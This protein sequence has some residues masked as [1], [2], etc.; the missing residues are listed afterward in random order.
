MEL[1]FN[2]NLNSKVMKHR[3]YILTIVFLI[4]A[5]IPFVA[6]AY[7]DDL[8]KYN[9]K[10]V[11]K[12]S[13]VYESPSIKPA[14]FPRLKTREGIF[15]YAK[16]L[17]YDL[18]TLFAT[19]DFEDI[20]VSAIELDGDK[21]EIRFHLKSAYFIS[22]VSFEG[23]VHFSNQQLREQASI[24]Y[25]EK[26]DET[27]IE[28]GAKKL[29]AYYNN[30]GYFNTHI[31]WEFKK[32]SESN[33]GELI[34]KISDAKPAY[35]NKIEIEGLYESAEGSNSPT[36]ELPGLKS[37]Q[38][39]RFSM[40]GINS[41]L[42]ES[43]LYLWD[44]NYFTT[45]LYLL[46]NTIDPATGSV[47]LKIK[48][49]TDGIISVVFNEK[50]IDA[51][52]FKG[53]LEGKP[54][55][56]LNSETQLEWSNLVQEYYKR[57]GYPDAKVYTSIFTMEQR[58][59][60]FNINIKKVQ[61]LV[62]KGKVKFIKEIDFTFNNNI[63]KNELRS[64]L[65]N[66]KDLNSGKILYTTDK[67]DQ[68][69]EQ[70]NLFYRSNGYLEAKVLQYDTEEFDQIEG[71]GINIKFQID[72][73]KQSRIKEIQVDGDMQ[74]DKDEIIRRIGID[75]GDVFIPAALEK[76]SATIRD[77]VLKTY[78]IEVEVDAK[79]YKDDENNA[80]IA[81][82]VNESEMEFIEQIIL[83][84]NF[85]TDSDFILRSID[86]KEGDK[87]TRSALLSSQLKL[88][89]LGLFANIEFTPLD[90]DITSQSKRVLLKVQETV[91]IL[92]TYGGGVDTE[93][94]V[95]GTF[96]ISHNNLGGTGKKADFSISLGSKESSAQLNYQVP[97][98][99]AD[100][101]DL[102]ASVYY[103][104]HQRESF[105]VTRQGAVLQLSTKS[106]LNMTY[107]L[108]FNLENV[109]LYD[110]KVSEYLI[111]P[112]ERAVNLTS[113]S[114]TMVMDY[115]NDPFNPRN[116]FFLSSSIKWA[117][118]LLGSKENFLKGYFQGSFYFP[119][120][121]DIVFALGFRLGV[122]H[123]FGDNIL[124]PPSERFFAGGSNTLRAYSLD[125][126]GPKDEETG[127][128]IGGNAM[129]IAN[130]E[131]RIPIFGSLGMVLFYDV[132]S[133]FER[134]NDISIKN[135]AKSVGIGARFNTPIGPLRVDFGVNPDDYNQSQ[136]YF[137][138]GHTF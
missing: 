70:I 60:I 58:D 15:F 134:S 131:I 11:S 29:L 82:T 57:K 14:G 63:S 120:I 133:V 84:G 72:E 5:V 13:F 117:N 78:G 47:S 89:D 135:L 80:Y 54:K 118:S 122:S 111:S 126:V 56:K 104:Q 50:D 130:A 33:S 43:K 40:S 109:D 39:D 83:N 128:P 121:E 94:L 66:D 37:L 25:M 49:N 46:D 36:P 31:T 127:Y 16:D 10:I 116:G 115:R 76:V 45:D 30:E 87:L 103:E 114:S 44:N 107:L 26:H 92:M 93:N 86:F 67:V 129:L 1:R 73:G 42:E 6:W 106:S 88:Y 2:L 124:L 35:I 7:Q 113:L 8:D 38:E 41:W 21:V 34:Y 32:E 23:D 81:I 85:Q 74:F 4:S 119:I 71:A 77:S 28:D 17:N 59:P 68:W 99:L 112:D 18:V 105:G 102:F 24:P 125:S 97:R 123:V 98:I 48:I 52:I 3:L 12:I 61:F 101:W 51:K 132:G 138:I 108:S 137:S 69:I 90:A 110:I 96:S 19:G 91:P 79:A 64:L 27:T 75:V 136:I 9:G 22:E 53:L 95:R 20:K 62:K 55:R 65:V 100:K